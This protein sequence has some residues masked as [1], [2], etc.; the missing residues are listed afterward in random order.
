MSKYE[1]INKNVFQEN[2]NEILTQFINHYYSCL[3]QKNFNGIFK[4]YKDFT[5]IKF[6]SVEYK[7]DSIENLYK[8]IDLNNI[9]YTIDSYDYLMS[10]NHRMD[11]LVSGKIQINEN[12]T[13]CFTEY[14]HF[15]SCKNNEIGYLIYSS[16]FKSF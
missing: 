7:G 16:I 6:D 14:V 9:L 15:G 13:K 1:N 2:S 11:I 5:K 8:K 12:E 3:N 10:G 4:F